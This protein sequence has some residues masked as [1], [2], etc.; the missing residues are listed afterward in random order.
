MTRYLKTCAILAGLLLSAGAVRAQFSMPKVTPAEAT[1]LARKDTVKLQSQ[2]QNPYFSESRWL[3]EKKRIRKER[4]TVEFNSSLSL[5]QNTYD[6]WAPG[7]DNTFALR[8]DVF[9]RHQ[10]K[11]EK[12]SLDYRFE[13]KYGLNYIDKKSFKNQDL[14]LFNASTSWALNQNWSYSASANF[15]TQFAKG[16]KSRT[17]DTLISDFMAPGTLDLAV[18]F[19]FQKPKS[20]F[21]L[22]L[23][24]IGGSMT[25]VLNRE[26]SEQGKFGVDKG[27]R[28]IS[29]LGSSIRADLDIEFA[30]KILRYRTTLYSFSNYSTNTYVRWDNLLEIRA[31]KFLAATLNIT[32]VYDKYAE[33]PRSK[34]IQM[35]YS[36]GI[37]LTYRYK[38]K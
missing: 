23:S 20:P 7:G 37:A 5:N 10:H 21:K 16:Y 24:P 22:N 19:T 1:A 32:G 26:L 18:G 6:N 35:N 31:T 38:N 30:K 8:G 14:I 33:T 13:A 3:A 34:A 36:I 28:Q 12:F 27:K 17:D 4:N 2:I 9:F 25:F 15:R 29:T 11:R